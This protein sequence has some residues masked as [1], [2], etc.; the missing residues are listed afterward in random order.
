MTTRG[1]G[2]SSV[3]DMPQLRCRRRSIFRRFVDV[4]LIVA[5]RV[6]LRGCTVVLLNI[7][8]NYA[9]WFGVV[10]LSARGQFGLAVLPSLVAVGIH[11]AVTPTLRRRPEFLLCLAAIPLG[12]CV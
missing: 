1:P 11:L 2:A 5:F 6:N 8:L 3:S 12:L 4:E 10:T 7:V 9:A